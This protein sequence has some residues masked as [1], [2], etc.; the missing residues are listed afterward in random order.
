MEK[1]AF[2]T[3]HGDV[4]SAWRQ[5]LMVLREQNTVGIQGVQRLRAYMDSKEKKACNLVYIYLQYNKKAK[6]VTKT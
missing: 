3:L 2:E 4:G 5:R 1:L 6:I